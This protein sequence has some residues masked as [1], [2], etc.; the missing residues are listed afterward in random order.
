M[1]S[2]RAKLEGYLKMCDRHIVQ[3]RMAIAKQRTRIGDLR[4]ARHDARLAESLLRSM[5]DSQRLH[6]DHRE[7]L[8]KEIDHA[9]D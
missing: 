9:V 1:G 6:E 2:F 4:E 5:L 7:C 3:G 8:L